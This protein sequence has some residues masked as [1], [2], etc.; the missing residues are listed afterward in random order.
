M[1]IIQESFQRLFPNREFDYSTEEFYTRQL[2]DFNANVKLYGKK[3][4]VKYNLQ[5]KS[6]DQ[7]I[8]I[9]LV[10]SLLLKL[11]KARKWEQEY[12]RMNLNLYN[13]FVK[14]IP[15]FCEKNKNDPVLEES[16]SRVN[17]KFFSGI[18]DKPNLTWGAHSTRKLASYNYHND[19]VTVSKVFQESREELLDYLMYHE[20]LHKQLKYQNSGNRNAFH[21]RRFKQAEN[22]Y[23]NKDLAEKEINGEIRKYHLSKNNLKRKINQKKKSLSKGLFSFFR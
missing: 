21:T 1:N 11:F 7:E 9:G 8:K 4:T 14:R 5:W 17:N 19:T 18:L 10:Q 16:F 15:E 3:I 6:V 12:S 2:S 13:D 20:L 22:M 23:P